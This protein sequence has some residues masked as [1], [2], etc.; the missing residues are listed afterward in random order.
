MAPLR[1]AAKFDLIPSFPW[2]APPR[3]PP[4]RNPRKGRDQILPSANQPRETSTLVE[5]V[6]TLYR[7]GRQDGLVV[8]EGQNSQQ[9]LAR[10]A[11]LEPLIFS[12]NSPTFMPLHYSD[13]IRLRFDTNVIFYERESG[14]ERRRIT[15]ITDRF[16]IKGGPPIALDLATWDRSGG[17]QLKAW[18]PDGYIQIFRVNELALRA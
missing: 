18:L 2:I 12:S 14:I 8:E 7:E 16:A 4:W 15:K 11:S 13:M 9:L 17:L 6:R 3:P 1:Y 10:I 5:H